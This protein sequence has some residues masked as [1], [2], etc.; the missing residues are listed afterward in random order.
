MA[1]KTFP[2][3]RD[4]CSKSAWS[5][6]RKVM[7][8]SHIFSTF[9]RLLTVN[10]P[11]WHTLILFILLLHGVRCLLQTS[12]LISCMVSTGCWPSKP[13]PPS[14]L[15]SAIL[16]LYIT[17]L[18][19]FQIHQSYKTQ[20]GHIFLQTAL[21]VDT[22]SLNNGD[23]IHICG[24]LSA[25]NCPL[26]HK[27]K[28]KS[29]LA[30]VSSTGPSCQGWIPTLLNSPLP[31]WHS[32]ALQGIIS[33]SMVCTCIFAT[34]FNVLHVKV[35]AKS[36]QPSLSCGKP[37]TNTFFSPQVLQDIHTLHLML[38]PSTGMCFWLLSSIHVSN[39]FCTYLMVFP[40]KKT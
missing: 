35:L 14:N 40:S 33:C 16:L 10:R 39:R 29:L 26:Q 13:S 31:W 36:V 7:L 19:V 23:G 25:Q 11:H 3:V 37:L 24:R 18:L 32:A 21:T 28:W 15:P 5:F 4:P 8:S 22:W 30:S 2:F 27:L 38:V 12:P 1:L 17:P 9:R 20:F 6:C 34:E